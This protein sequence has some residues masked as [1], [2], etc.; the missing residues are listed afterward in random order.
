M[1]HKLCCGNI[2][3]GK[4]LCIT[5]PFEYCVSTFIQ[6]K[7][8]AVRKDRH[9]RAV[10]EVIT[11]MLLL[12]I[13][14]IGALFVASFF[15][16][17]NTVGMATTISSIRSPPEFIKLTGFDT[18]DAGNLSGISTLTNFLTTVTPSTTKKLCTISCVT[19]KDRIPASSNGGTEFIVLKIRNA[20]ANSVFLNNILIDNVSHI[21]DDSTAG[22][23][24]D[25]SGNRLSDC[26]TKCYP[27]AGMFSIISPSNTAPITQATSTEIHGGEEVRLV[28]KLS[29]GIDTNPDPVINADIKLNSALHIFINTGS[30]E[31]PEF[32]IGSGS[33]R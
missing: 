8:F 22:K 14:V 2:N 32:V 13:T 28:I 11:T 15:Q 7:S 26:S 1:T 19:N 10:S 5:Q 23:T 30:L 21:L 9:R 6:T 25:A 24:L 18:R 27:N 12:A 31:P 20:S 16:S 4:K 33:A 29:E 3:S 17:G